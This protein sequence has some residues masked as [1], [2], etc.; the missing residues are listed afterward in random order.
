M[1]D[2]IDI[3]ETGP[4]DLAA[5]EAL[6]PAAFPAED[7][8]P[9]VRDLL[10]EGAA[11]LSLAAVAG[12]RPVAHVAFTTCGLTGGSD[13]A[14][15]LAPLAVAPDRQGRGIGS[16]LVRAGLRRLARAGVAHVF[17]LGD[18]AYY[19]RFGFVPEHRVAPPYPLPAAWREAWQSLALDGAQAPPAGKLTVPRPWRDP[20]LWAP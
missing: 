1:P 18:P 7:L 10:K 16:A 17:V 13:K 15:L 8:L 19:G 14:A 20:K 5:L 2:D 9:L 11:V 4:D 12:A 6:Y 3:R